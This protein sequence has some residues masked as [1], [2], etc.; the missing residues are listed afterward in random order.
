MTDNIHSE[1]GGLP[2]PIDPT[3]RVYRVP[4]TFRLTLDLYVLASDE[5]TAVVA[6]QSIDPKLLDALWDLDDIQLWTNEPERL[7]IGDAALDEVGF[8]AEECSGY[9]PTDHPDWS[10]TPQR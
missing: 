5:A 8:T 3:R 1:G 2:P 4:I 7:R 6:A 9:V 10:P